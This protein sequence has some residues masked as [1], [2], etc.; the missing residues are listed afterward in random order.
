MAAA[1]GLAFGSPSW[2]AF[3]HGMPITSHVV[4]GEGR[5]DFAR[6]QSLFGLVRAHGGSQTLAWAVQLVGSMVVAALVVWLWRRREPYEL[7]A[8][9]LAAG[10]LL[11]TPYVYMYDLVVLGVAVAFLLRHAIERGLVEAEAAALAAARRRV[12]LFPLL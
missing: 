1:S 4:L 9:A 3:F 12:F 11:V 10:A 2:Q 7:K 8:A 6:L 5:A